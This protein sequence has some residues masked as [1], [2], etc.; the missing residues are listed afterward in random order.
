MQENIASICKRT[1]F[2]SDYKYVD[3]LYFAMCIWQ[4]NSS[5][6][7]VRML[8]L[9]EDVLLIGTTTNSILTADLSP[10]AVKSPLMGC[11]VQQ[12]PL[13]VVRIHDGPQQMRD[14]D[15]VLV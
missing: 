3:L 12:L 10:P 4:V 5:D 13:T 8:Q 9:H 14:V 11:S 7:G 6:G 1:S 15:P 2:V